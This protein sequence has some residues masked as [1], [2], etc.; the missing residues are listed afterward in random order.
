MFKRFSF[1][2]PGILVMTS[3]A[4]AHFAPGDHSSFLSGFTHPL[5][6]IDHILVM[7]AV[8]LWAVTIGGR[9]LWLVPSAFVGC[10][11][12]GYLLALD[13]VQ[14]PFIEPA[15]LASVVAL[16]VLVAMSARLPLVLGAPLVGTFALF[17]GAAHA[18]ELGSASSLAFG[19][20]FA[21][22]TALLH[23]AGIGI[24]LL[25]ASGAGIGRKAG[26]ILARALGGLVVV[27]GLVLAF[28][29]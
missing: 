6:G 28:T 7:V 27:C 3:P 18:S 5:F 9:A 16:G 26:N 4:F 10:M 1:A 20:G 12:F 11:M 23:G 22:A 13:G 14:L 29:G 2:I 15:V 8:G 17:H 25:L 24:G 21:F 19:V